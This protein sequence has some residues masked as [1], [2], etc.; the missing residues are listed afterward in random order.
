MIPPVAGSRT[1]VGPAYYDSQQPVT[2][3]NI[4]EILH[5]SDC[6]A[7]ARDVSSDELHHHQDVPSNV[8]EPDVSSPP[9][10]IQSE[11]ANP[12][13]SPLVVIDPFPH[14]SPGAPISRGS[15]MDHMDREAS[16]DLIWTPFGSQCEWEITYWPKKQ[17]LTSSATADFVTAGTAVH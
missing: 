16:N 6:P 14:G 5:E 8:S 12:S 2:D 13:S 10:D 3:A 7:T 11:A 4:L 15:H 1:Y 17:G 9:P